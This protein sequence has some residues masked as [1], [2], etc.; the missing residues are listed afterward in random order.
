MAAMS[1]TAVL[2]ELSLVRRRKVRFIVHPVRHNIGIS[3]RMTGDVQEKK[4]IHKDRR[5]AQSEQLKQR[6]RSAAG[7]GA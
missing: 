2:S 3:G 1:E 7:K 5:A 6:K 4:R